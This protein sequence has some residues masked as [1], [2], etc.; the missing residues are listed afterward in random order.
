M[1]SPNEYRGKIRVGI[2][3]V[4]GE[5]DT[6]VLITEIEQPYTCRFDGEV[7]GPTGTIKGVATFH[8]EDLGENCNLHYSSEALITGALSKLNPRLVEGSVQTLMHFGLK[9]LNLRLKSGAIEKAE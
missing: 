6:R 2:A 9:K 3:A 5:Y 1:V 7:A 8:L 4:G